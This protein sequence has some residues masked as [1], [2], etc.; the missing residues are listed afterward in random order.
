MADLTDRIVGVESGGNAMATNPRSS[1]AGAGQFLANTWLTMMQR[2]RPDLAAGKTREQIL[3]LRF[4]PALSREMTQRYAEENAKYLQSRGIEPTPGNTY[5]AHFAGSG[6]AAA[7]HANPQAPVESTLG[8]RAVAANPF[9]RGKT[10]Q[11]VI[12]WANR[13]MGSPSQVMADN[14]RQRFSSPKTEGGAIAGGASNATL[15]GGEGL[16]RLKA[17]LGGKTYNPDQIAAY[18][19]IMKTGQD[20]A[21]KATNWQTALLGTVTAGAGGYLQGR[22]NEKKK[23]FDAALIDA[24]QGVRSPTELA[25]LLIASPDEKI[26]SA[27]LELLTKNLGQ[28]PQTRTID[29]PYGQK[30]QQDYINGQWVTAGGSQSSTPTFGPAAAQP[31]QQPV[32]ATQPVQNIGEVGPGPQEQGAMQPNSFAGQVSNVAAKGDMLPIGGQ[33]PSSVPASPAPDQPQYRIGP[34]VPKPPEGFVHKLAPDGSGYLYGQDGQPLFE[35]KSAAEERGK[36][37]AGLEAETASKARVAEQFG[38]SLELLRRM[39]RDF[40]QQAFDRA[41]GPWSAST[42]QDEDPQGGFWGSGLSIDSIGRNIARADAEIDRLFTGGAAPTEVRDRVET[43]MK[44]LAAVMK[45]LVR[46]PGEGAWSDKDQANLEKQIGALTR[47]RSVDEY[48][49]RVNDIKENVSKTFS[50]DVP[51]KPA[52]PRSANAPM[53]AEADDTA[54]ERYRK[55]YLGY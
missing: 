37:A 27:G 8:S 4:D 30:I 34:A 31:T 3:Q 49:R 2:Y 41:I 22:E 44:N 5:L 1:A 7:L 17:A 26:K 19:N 25:Q 50:I 33:Q 9:L 6:G 24:V 40:G 13:K 46:K 39:P 35:P 20:V 21:G 11:D 23:E 42:P 32:E 51:Q 36:A 18:G 12:D 16:D 54:W 38:N 48:L 28:A 43:E 15:A 52:L 53:T 47:A 45:P 10:G 29:G 55:Q 14:L